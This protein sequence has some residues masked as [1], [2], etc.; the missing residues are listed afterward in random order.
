MIC[1]E[2]KLDGEVSFITETL[3]N[4]SFPE[5]IVRSL[6]RD[7]IVHFHKTKVASAQKCPIY[8]RLHWLGDISDC[9]AY[10]ISACVRKF[11]FSSNLC[12]VFR[13]RTALPSERC[14][15]HPQHS[16]ALIYSFGCVCG[17]KYI[18][19]TNQRLDAR[20]K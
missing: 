16:S 14:S 18:G 11:Y 17:L 3:F 8:L 7:K 10:Q 6:I 1:S 12:V 5:D 15:P 19:R 20:I 2:S 13:T 9:F 4:N